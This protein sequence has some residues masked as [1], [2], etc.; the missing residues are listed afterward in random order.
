MDRIEKNNMAINEIRIN[1]IFSFL[2]SV[3]TIAKSSFKVEKENTIEP[4][5][6][7][8]A[9]VPNSAL[10]Y[11]L[12]NIG[13]PPILISCAPSVPKERIETFFKKMFFLKFNTLFLRFSK[14]FFNTFF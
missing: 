10:L 13:S 4:N 9:S 8:N 14:K 3:F 6:M 1:A 5:A 12:D 2:F 11:I 7:N